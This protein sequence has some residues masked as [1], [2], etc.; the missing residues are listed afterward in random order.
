VFLVVLALDVF[1][2]AAF[3]RAPLNLPSP[4][5]AV[6][7]AVLIAGVSRSMQWA[8]DR[9]PGPR[10]SLAVWNLGGLD[11]YLPGLGPLAQAY[12]AAVAGI[13]MTGILAFGAVRYMRMRR[14]WVAAGVSVAAVAIASS[15]TPVQFAA[16]AVTAS[17]WLAVLVLIAMTCAADL[18]GLGVAFFWLAALGEALELLRQ[19]SPFIRWNGALSALL[20]VLAGTV[21]LVVLQQ[22]RRGRLPPQLSE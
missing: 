10:P 11:T 17:L 9:V 5:R 3:G 13:G 2:Q 15:L 18:I 12:M 19:P 4:S 1:R 22:R 8:L 21:L 20:A 14:R 7:A 16:H 6:A